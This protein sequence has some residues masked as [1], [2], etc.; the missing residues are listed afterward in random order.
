EVQHLR[1]YVES[2]MIRRQE[3]DLILFGV[4]FDTWFSEQSMHE[5]GLVART[6]DKLK[7]IGGADSEPIQNVNQ[8]RDLE[9]GAHPQE[10]GATWLRSAKFGDDKDR[11]L[12]RGDGRPAY[13]AGDLAY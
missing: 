3:N 5:S 4:H 13:I 6:I 11:V 7:K 8:D 1:H 10:P 9:P 12:V 2:G